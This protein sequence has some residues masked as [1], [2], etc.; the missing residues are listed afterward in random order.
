MFILWDF[1][2]RLTHISPAVFSYISTRKHVFWL[3]CCKLFK[4]IYERCHP[5]C[6]SGC[7]SVCPSLLQYALHYL[8]Q[9]PSL[10]NESYSI[11]KKLHL[12]F[13]FE[14][15]IP[16]FTHSSFPCLSHLSSFQ[17]FKTLKRVQRMSNVRRVLSQ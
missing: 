9:F 11:F 1:F 13:E 10:E 7:T 14:T 4:H 3:W 17:G 15:L 16:Q 2:N 8:T 5:V 6:C 12:F